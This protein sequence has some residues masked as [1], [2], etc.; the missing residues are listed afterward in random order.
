MAAKNAAKK[1]HERPPPTL[2]SE[3]KVKKFTELRKGH[4]RQGGDRTECGTPGDPG[5]KTE[6]PH[7]RR[8]QFERETNALDNALGI[9][10]CEDDEQRTG[11]AQYQNQVMQPNPAERV[12]QRTRLSDGGR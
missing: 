8:G 3:L 12:E 5:A 1:R 4:D 9:G 2:R 6:E 11:I 10:Q 7:A